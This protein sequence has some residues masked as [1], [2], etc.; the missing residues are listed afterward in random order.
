MLPHGTSIPRSLSERTETR[1]LWRMP[2][3]WPRWRLGPVW[4]RCRSGIDSRSD[5]RLDEIR[6]SGR[7][8]LS[9]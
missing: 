9:R 8:T 4:G 5:C 7:P 3:R 2:N 6:P 1:R